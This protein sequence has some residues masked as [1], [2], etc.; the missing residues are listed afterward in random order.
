MLRMSKLTDYGT[1]VMTYLARESGRLHTANEIAAGVH[2]APPTASKILKAL[3]HKGLVASHRG[4]KG[5]YTLARA[6]EDI[7]VVQVID[8]IEGPVGL[9][10]CSNSPGVCAQEPHCSVRGN[11]QRISRTIREALAEVS[12]AEM[13][14]PPVATHVVRFGK[15][16][17]PTPRA[18]A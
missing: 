5:G 4:I 9:T 11:W 12:L 10:E 18:P 14:K 2:L 17:S 8:A 15:S 6:A 7:S 1:A 3:V 16:P 13:A